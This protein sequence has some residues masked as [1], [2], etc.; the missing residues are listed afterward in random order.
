MA[1]HLVEHTIKNNPNYL[2]NLKC[3]NPILCASNETTLNLFRKYRP[4]YISILSNH[5]AFINENKYTIT[6]ESKKYDLIINSSFTKLKRLHLS[7]LI[8]N[9]I[10]IGYKCGPEK[11]FNEC[12][13]KDGYIPNFHNRQRNFKNWKMVNNNEVISYINQSKVGGI[14]SPAEG[15]CFSSS[16]YILCGVPVVSTYCIGGREFWYDGENCILCEPKKDNIKN[17]IENII[18][19][20]DSNK[21]NPERIRNN[22]I[23]KMNIQR[24]ILTDTVYNSFTKITYNLPKYD[25]LYDSLK[26]YHS[27][28]KMGD[29]LC[30]QVQLDKELIALS[31]IG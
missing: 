30:D 28:N 7:E 4:Q 9:K 8:S 15:A 11:E 24:K 25:V 18:N 16:E 13:P 17:A 20:N 26:F 14:F 31:I 29:P 1:H 12:L 19:N 21:F 6:N 22:H 3:P 10:Y 5:N 27:N 23:K 2:N